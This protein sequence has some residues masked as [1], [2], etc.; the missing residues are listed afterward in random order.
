MGARDGCE[1]G[2]QRDRV[3]MEIGGVFVAWHVFGGCVFFVFVRE[4]VSL[5]R[6]EVS[7]RSSV[8]NK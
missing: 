2:G 4:S 7:E 1:A 8:V 6:I 3:L 5:L